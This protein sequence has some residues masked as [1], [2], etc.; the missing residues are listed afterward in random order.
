MKNGRSQQPEAAPLLA[1]GNGAEYVNG[2]GSTITVGYGTGTAP[3]IAFASASASSN[4]KHGSSTSDADQ[5]GSFL[6]SLSNRF[7]EIYAQ[8]TGT[9]DSIRCVYETDSFVL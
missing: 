6:R 2:S 4:S 3:S 9:C 8:H 5:S 7:G 1:T